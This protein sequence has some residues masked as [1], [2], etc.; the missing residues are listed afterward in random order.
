[1][2]LRDR[3]ALGGFAIPGQAEI[4]S[5]SQSLIISSGF[6]DFLADFPRGMQ[7]LTKLYQGIEYFRHLDGEKHLVYVTERGMSLPR[8]EDHTSVAAMANDARVVIDTIQTG[9]LPT[10]GVNDPVPFQET[11]NIHSLRTVSELTGGLSSISSHANRAMDRIVSATSSAYLLGYAP[12]DSNFDGKYRRISVS[13]SRRGAKA[14]WRHGYFARNPLLPFDHRMALTYNRIASATTATM[15]IGDI[16][17]NL[18]ADEVRDGTGLGLK[19]DLQIDPS[20]LAWSRNGTDRTA[21]IDIAMFAIDRNQEIAG[22]HWQ[23]LPLRLSAELLERAGKT[24]L[25]Y[26]VR[27]PLKT[28]ITTVK[29]VVYN[30]DSDLIGTGSRRLR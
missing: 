2:I 18:S 12:A 8:L 28:E 26:S 22:E 10:R 27:I 23:H 11:F 1:M 5:M 21:A 30:F 25:S 17:F 6:A 4:G 3:A 15:E 16:K 20:R 14:Y 24:G 7:D 29:V 13:V 9:G 19:V